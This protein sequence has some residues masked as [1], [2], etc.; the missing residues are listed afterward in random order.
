MSRKISALPVLKKLADLDKQNEV[1][2]FPIDTNLKYA[3]TGKDGWGEIT[4]AVS[5]NVVANIDKFVGSLYIAD[6]E[7]YKQIEE[8]LKGGE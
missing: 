3:R 7:A 4:I 5:N 8:E 2:A 1:F 6:K